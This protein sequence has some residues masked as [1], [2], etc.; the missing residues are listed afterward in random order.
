VEEDDNSFVWKIDDGK[1]KRV[2]IK[3]GLMGDLYAEVVQGVTSKDDVIINPPSTLKEGKAV[4]PSKEPL[5]DAK[6]GKS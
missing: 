2:K 4:R 6:G 5:A 1:A 3:T